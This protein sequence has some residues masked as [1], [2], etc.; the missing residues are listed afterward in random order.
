MADDQN[1]QDYQDGQGNEPVSAEDFKKQREINARLQGQLRSLEVE[2]DELKTKFKDVNVEEYKEIKSKLT[3]AERKAAE[4][5]PEKMKELIER[6]KRAIREEY[7]GK[8]TP[9]QQEL[10]RLKR[11]NKTLAVTDKVIG[12]IGALFVPEALKWIKEEITKNCDREEDGTIVVKDENGEPLYVGAR[13][14]TIKE[15]GDKLVNQFPFAAK[16][17][18]TP[19]TKDSAP[20]QKTKGIRIPGT[21]AE[22]M[23]MPNGTAIWDKMSN[24]ERRALAKGSKVT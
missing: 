17:T 5:N 20:G 11:E 21:L 1:T 22:L 16:P 2:R 9:L 13:L 4:S 14:M 12:E 7:E 19:G 6:D 8:L 23:A 18:G 15:Y 3:E 24:E 10:E